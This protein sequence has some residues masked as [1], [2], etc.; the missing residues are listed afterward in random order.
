MEALDLAGGSRRARLGED[1]V[2]A[3]LPADAVE[4]DLDRW[5]GEAPRE[6]LAVVGQDLARQAVRPQSRTEA[7]ADRL[8]SLAGHE[9]G[10]D[11]EPRVVVDAGQGLGC[12]PV[13][14]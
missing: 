10:R 12:A 1:V 13:G 14:E 5:L 3:V 2:D 4:Q 11:A 7:V 9:A 8:R 6:D